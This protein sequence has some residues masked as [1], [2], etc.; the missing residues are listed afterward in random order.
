MN[1]SL[2]L[3]FF[4][5]FFPTVAEEGK[6]ITLVSAWRLASVKT[7]QWSKIVHFCWDWFVQYKFRLGQSK[8]CWYEGEG[9]VCDSM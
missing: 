5:L 1:H 4:P 9:H 6:Q 7:Q 8:R 2:I 3:F